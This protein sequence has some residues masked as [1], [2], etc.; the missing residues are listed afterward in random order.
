MAPEKRLRW[1]SS[2]Y[3]SMSKRQIFD[4]DEMRELADAGVLYLCC[5]SMPDGFL[6]RSDSVFPHIASF[7]Y[8]V[9]V[10]E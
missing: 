3:A 4:E 10:E 8:Y 6:C 9:E 1:E 5:P 7:V 2:G